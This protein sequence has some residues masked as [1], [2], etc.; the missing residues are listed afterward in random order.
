MQTVEDVTENEDLACIG[1]VVFVS[2]FTSP[3]G[4]HLI[5]FGLIFQQLGPIESTKPLKM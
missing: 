1:H 2:V 3:C 4:S 5:A